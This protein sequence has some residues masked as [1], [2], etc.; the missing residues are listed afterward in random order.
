MVYLL[1]LEITSFVTIYPT[2]RRGAVRGDMDS[3]HLLGRCQRQYLPGTPN[4]T[5]VLCAAGVRNFGE[6][7]LPNGHQNR[8]LGKSLIFARN[9]CR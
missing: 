4:F 7:N 5:V 6:G 2:F 3:G 9:V 8:T 1:A